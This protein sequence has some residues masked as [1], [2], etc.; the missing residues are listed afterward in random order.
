MSTKITISHG[1][2]YHLWEEI[3]DRSNV[4]LRV[5]GHEYETSNGKVMVQ[6]PIEV[7]RSM[8]QDWSKRGWSEK[9]DGTETEISNNWLS[10]LESIIEDTESIKNGDK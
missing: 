1:K 5:E 4:Y 7:W 8:I 2:N 3:F 6:I 9:E 10:S